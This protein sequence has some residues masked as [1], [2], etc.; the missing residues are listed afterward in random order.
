MHGS[1]T[2]IHSKKISSGSVA[3]RDLIPAFKGQNV[4]V[5]VPQL[6]AVTNKSRITGN[7]L[8]PRSGTFHLT[9]FTFAVCQLAMQFC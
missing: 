9:I 7:I 1:R 5:K 3:W 6:S 8:D 4:S 2:K